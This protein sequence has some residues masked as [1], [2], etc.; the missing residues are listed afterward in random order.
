MKS[1]AIAALLGVLPIHCDPEPARPAAAQQCSGEHRDEV[2][3]LQYS[4]G[5]FEPVDAAFRMVAADCGWSQQS[6]DDWASF[7]VYDVVAKESGGCW[8]VR[9]GVRFADSGANCAIAR[10]GRGSDSGF[11]QLIGIHYKGNGWLCVEDGLCSSDAIISSPYT[12]M[13]ALVR[14]VG[15]S[16]AKPGSG[17]QG[18]CYSKWARNYHRGCATA[19]GGTPELVR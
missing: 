11:G 6:I 1:L 16:V 17:K 13:Q 15:G 12:S 18:W 4:Y 10:Q 19:P 2:N 7:L 14:L 8:N 9:R 5:V 3:A